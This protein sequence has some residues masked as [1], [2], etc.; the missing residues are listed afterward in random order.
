MVRV[1]NKTR[2]S[3]SYQIIANAE[4]QTFQV[5]GTRDGIVV[6]SLGEEVRPVIISLTRDDYNGP[7]PLTFT[8]SQ[9]G[10]VSIVQREAEFIGPDPKR[11]KASV[12]E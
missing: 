1:I 5:E 8:L 11:L 2:N 12:N 7:F 9:S 4:G 10:D 6:P 3:Q